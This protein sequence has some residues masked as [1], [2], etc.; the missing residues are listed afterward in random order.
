MAAKITKI[1]DTELEIEQ[2]PEKYTMN[3][4]YIEDRILHFQNQIIKYQGMLKIFD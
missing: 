3:K 4:K 1:S 2:E